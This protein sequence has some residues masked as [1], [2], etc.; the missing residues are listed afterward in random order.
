MSLNIL[1][2]TFAL[3]KSKISPISTD[4]SK[5]IQPKI[6]L[7]AVI[8]HTQQKLKDIYTNMANNI[9]MKPLNLYNFLNIKIYKSAVCL[10]KKNALVLV[11]FHIYIFKLT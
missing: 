6:H 9:T 1:H 3:K 2:V 11:A 7:R 10:Q 4:M 8:V 5:S